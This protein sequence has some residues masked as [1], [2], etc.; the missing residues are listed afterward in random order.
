MTPAEQHLPS[1]V[2][3][4]DLDH[5]LSRDF[6]RSYT[7]ADSPFLAI[8]KILWRDRNGL[9]K[10]CLVGLVL[11][12]LIAVFTPNYYT[13][14]ARLMPPDTSN[15]SAL[16]LLS[17]VTGKIGIPGATAASD[18]LGMKST[19]TTF[20]AIL[21]SRTVQDRL[22]DEFDLR[23]VYWRKTYYDTRQKL[24]SRTDVSEDKKSGVITIEVTDR[25][26]NRAAKL[27]DAY[28]QELNRLV[29]SL[30]T[31]SAHRERVF[32][33]QRL[34]VVKNDL[35]D[36]EKQFAEY[37]SRNSTVDIKE[38]GRAMVEAAASLEG[39]YIAA[40]SQ[41]Q[42][43]QQIYSDQN[44][45]VRSLKARVTELQKQLDRVA[46]QDVQTGSGDLSTSPFPS[47][48][49]LP[50][51]GQRYADLYRRVKVQETV[52]ETLTGQYELA[53]VQEAKEI[54]TVKVLDNPE[55]PEKKSF[56]P[57]LLLLLAMALIMVGVG[58]AITIGKELW[59]EIDPREPHKAF[60]QHVWSEL[61]PRVP[62]RLI[63]L[64]VSRDKT[65]FSP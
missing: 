6:G 34:S 20:V 36:A 38:Q 3:Q 1:V 56:P 61:G 29:A 32:L 21:Q 65:D 27:A 15:N 60:L 35:Q 44:V 48:R 54:P 51:L 41:L 63:K 7:H 14:T 28:V 49:E 50:L 62:K 45:R 19:G 24:E 18:L 58:C 9:K 59:W 25:D 52:Y 39:E 40:Q 30:T 12:S 37:S 57:R 11:G 64:R 16:G 2:E 31:S 53:R 13:A 22:I 42:G 55:P 43:L 4:P 10:Y 23:K 26:R 8:S 5:P 46:G 47:I 17:M 33:E